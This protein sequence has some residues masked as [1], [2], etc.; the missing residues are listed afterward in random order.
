L[1]NNGLLRP[2]ARRAIERAALR[3]RP[4]PATLV[5]WQLPAKAGDISRGVRR[6]SPAQDEIMSC[7]DRRRFLDKAESLA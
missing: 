7:I 3:L 1:L 4:S 5:F 2:T 6:R